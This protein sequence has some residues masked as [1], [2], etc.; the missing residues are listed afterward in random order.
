MKNICTF[1]FLFLFAATGAFTQVGVNTD[2]STPDPSAMLDVKS[3]NKGILI[4][5]LTLAQRNAIANPAGGLMIYQ[6]DNS[7]VCIII[8]AAA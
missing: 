6:T 1:L 5:R 8:P 2:N 3:T 7:P 4:P